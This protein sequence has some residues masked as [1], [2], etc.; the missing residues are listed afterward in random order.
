MP[1]E[2]RAS[3]QDQRVLGANR[4]H[5]VGNLTEVPPNTETGKRDITQ[6]RSTYRATGCWTRE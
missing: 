4:L 2:E 3:H 5:R 6:L 1:R